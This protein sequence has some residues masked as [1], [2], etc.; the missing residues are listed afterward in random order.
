[1]TMITPEIAEVLKVFKV[2]APEIAG[3]AGIDYDQDDCTIIQRLADSGAVLWK[4]RHYVKQP[5]EI[6]AEY[7][8][9]VMVFSQI[10]AEIDVLN[11]DGAGADYEALL[12]DLM[13]RVME[14]A[15]QFGI[16]PKK[17]NFIAV[18]PMRDNQAI[19]VS[20]GINPDT[21]KRAVN[22][23]V[24]D[25]TIVLPT[26]DQMTAGLQRQA[27]Y[28]R[29]QGERIVPTSH[30]EPFLTTEE[31]GNRRFHEQ[32]QKYLTELKIDTEEEDL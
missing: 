16:K 3:H 4:V 8:D 24:N 28:D 2:F 9:K 5:T 1:M 10:N 29:R 19:I 23:E 22:V 32:V 25:T 21:D 31:Q 15:D 30:Q 7:N 27:T 26:Y 11:E 20:A 17:D 6:T 12:N 13:A 18:Q 14:R